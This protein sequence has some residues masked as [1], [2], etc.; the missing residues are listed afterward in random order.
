MEAGLRNEVGAGVAAFVLALSEVERE[1]DFG[2][3]LFRNVEDVGI[4]ADQ[5]EP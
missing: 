1:D 3:V 2:I 4:G 5:V